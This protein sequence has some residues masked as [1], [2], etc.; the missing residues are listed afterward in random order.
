MTTG[1][2]SKARGRVLLVEDEV[3]LARPLQFNLEEEGYDVSTTASG[4][5]ALDW[6]AE[7]GFDLI[8]LD[9]MIED[10]DGF[11]VARQVR[12]RDPRLPIL[13]LTARTAD[14]DRVLGLEIGADDYMVK[15]FHL[16]ELLLR[17][18]RMLQRGRWYVGQTRKEREVQIAGFVAN[19]EQLTGTGPR[20]PLQFTALEAD[21]L[22]LLA[23]EPN[24]VFSRAELLQKVWGYHSDVET[25]TVDNFIMRLRRYFEKE[26]D[27]PRHFVSVRGRGYVYVP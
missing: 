12:R 26:P 23:S 8:I 9:L 10:I 22:E 5:E 2:D 6:Q 4:K 14:A 24:R 7:R 21:L 27:N 25:R 18:Q 20:G 15:P 17:V 3:N 1:P 11:E 13:M 16:R 19:L